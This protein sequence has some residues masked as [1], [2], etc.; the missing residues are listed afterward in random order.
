MHQIIWK[1]I[2]VTWL[3]INITEMSVFLMF[4]TFW[5][6]QTMQTQVSLFRVFTVCLQEFLL[7]I[8]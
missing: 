3:L 5:D 4:N 2:K 7:E 1:E 8:E 6:L